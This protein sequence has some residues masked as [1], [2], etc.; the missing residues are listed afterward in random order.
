M[1]IWPAIDIQNGQCVRLCQGDFS[2]QSVYNTSVV[3]TAARWVAMGAQRLHFV[4]LNA[5]AGDGDNVAAIQA[6]LAELQASA[7][8]VDYANLAVQVGGGVRSEAAIDRYL[9]A[10]ATQLVCGTRAI[11]EPDWFETMTGRYPSR[12][13]LGLDARQGLVAVNGWKQTTVWTVADAIRRVADL[14]LAGIVYTDI[15]RDGM[16]SGPNLD[17]LREVVALTAIPIIASGGVAT[18][19]DIRRVAETGAAGCIIGKALY[20]GRI[21]LPDALAAATSTAAGH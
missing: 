21:A 10:G 13:V 20:E 18:L 17:G 3:E 12:L 4:D 1:E 2:R 15:Q 11:R 8:E 6:V 9:A 7:S 5:A 19:D 16:L 14:P